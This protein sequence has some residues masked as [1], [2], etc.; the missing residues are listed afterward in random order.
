MF[1]LVRVR[2][3]KTRDLGKVRCIKGEDSQVLVEEQRLRRDGRV[4]FLSFLMA[5][6][7]SISYA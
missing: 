2:E 7:V 6:G 3:K 1:K 4:T 5:R